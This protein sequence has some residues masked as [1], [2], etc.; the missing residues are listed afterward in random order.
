MKLPMV[1]T[2]PHSQ[3]LL[4]VGCKV[5]LTLLVRMREDL[6]PYCEVTYFDAGHTGH[7]G[8]DALPHHRRQR[9]LSLAASEFVAQ[10]L[11][12][13]LPTA[14]I[15]QKNVLRIEQAWL[16]NRSHAESGMVR[17]FLQLAPSLGVGAPMGR[18]RLTLMA[19]HELVAC[20]LSTQDFMTWLS[21]HPESQE[22][23]DAALSRKDVY[24][25]QDRVLPNPYKLDKD[26]VGDMLIAQ[27]PSDADP[28]ALPSSIMTARDAPL[29]LVG[30]QRSHVGRR[31]ERSSGG[32]GVPLPDAHGGPVLRVGPV[33]A[34]HAAT[35]SAA[36]ARQAPPHGRHVRHERPQG[37]QRH[38][39]T[40]CTI[41]RTYCMCCD[42]AMVQ[43]HL[44]IAHIMISV[45]S[46]LAVHRGGDG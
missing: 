25:I 14:R 29:S 9:W 45:R 8:A 1:M 19:M 13:G 36:R 40:P 35:G 3:H 24:N 30:T 28:V 2:Q 42:A 17:L 41:T 21:A 37:A 16:S 23:R 38:S 5:R 32:P 43:A 33:V 31:L 26:Q 12:F 44:R 34:L 46:V 4:Q 39:V 7:V 18:P 10:S 6:Q 27:G 22:A 20:L 15:L 11:S